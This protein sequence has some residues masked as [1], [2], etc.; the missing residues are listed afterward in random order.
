MSRN[1]VEE[2][3]SQLADRLPHL[4]PALLDLYTLLALEFGT[5]TDQVMVHNAWAVWRNRSQ[6]DHPSLIPFPYLAPEVQELDE[7][8][9]DAIRQAARAFDEATAAGQAPE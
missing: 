8:Y 5:T 2:V 7:P 1:Y 9:A 3:R 6:P 4:D